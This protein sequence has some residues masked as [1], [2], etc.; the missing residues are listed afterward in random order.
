[1]SKWFES[2]ATIWQVNGPGE[3]SFIT[4][5]QYSK[6]PYTKLFHHILFQLKTY[7][8]SCF[9]ILKLQHISEHCTIQLY[10]WFSVIKYSEILSIMEV[11]NTKHHKWYRHL[12]FTLCFNS[13]CPVP[14]ITT[15][16]LLW[17]Q[18]TRGQYQL[19][20]NQYLTTIFPSIVM[21][22]TICSELIRVLAD[23]PHEISSIFDTKPHQTRQQR[24][25]SPDN[26]NL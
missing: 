7:L 11:I 3:G 8:P 18:E 15:L 10:T 17:F 26:D 5:L 16:F 20:V 25:R 13:N 4:I 6:D 23:M 19:L 24:L 12:H 14:S 22:P 9:L 21:R 2:T 1:M